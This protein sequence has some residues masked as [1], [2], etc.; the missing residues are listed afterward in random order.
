MNF[1]V[2]GCCEGPLPSAG[3]PQAPRSSRTAGLKA[4]C[5]GPPP[6]Q[7]LQGGHQGS[8][9][10]PIQLRLSPR[11]FGR[12]DTLR[13]KAM[14]AFRTS[15]SSPRPSPSRRGARTPGPLRPSQLQNI[16]G[17]KRSPPLVLAS[18]QHH[19][20]YSYTYFSCASRVVVPLAT[21]HP[22]SNVG[23]SHVTVGWTQ[24]TATLIRII[25]WLKTGTSQLHH[26]LLCFKPRVCQA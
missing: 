21:A 13:R 25:F 16:G 3:R 10:P 1:I 12:T 15:P 5:G 2:E 18:R 9:A 26:S 6:S 20:H 7:A 23:H 19:Y 4:P 17:F 11:R 24:Q 8:G 22:L 14:R